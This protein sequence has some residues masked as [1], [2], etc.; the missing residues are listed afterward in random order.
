[1]TTLETIRA[2]LAADTGVRALL[3]DAVNDKLRIYPQVIEQGEASPA[4]VITVISEAPVN[5]ING[6]VSARVFNARVQVDAY[7]EVYT[8]AH[9][10]ADAIDAALSALARPDLS[11][12]RDNKQDLYDDETGQHRVSQDFSVFRSG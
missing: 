4:A 6:T 9:A 10:V 11:A 5:T 2:V 3:Y 12:Y 1:M 7:A 8:T